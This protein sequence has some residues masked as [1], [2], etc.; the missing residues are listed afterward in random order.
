MW[1]AALERPDADTRSQAAAAIGLAHQRGMKEL[2][3][4]IGPLVRLLEKQDEHSAVRLAAARTLII[5]D[6]REAAPVLF[7]LIDKG[8]IE[9]REIIEPALAVWDHKP[10]RAMWLERL[11]QPPPH[12]RTLLLAIH[13]LGTV[14][15]EKALDGLRTLM[16]DKESPLPYRLA[17]ARALGDI[18]P[19]GFEADAKK[20]MAD[21]SGLL[22]ASVLRKHKSDESI[23]LLQTLAIDGEPGVA[24]IAVSRLVEIDAALVL[25]VI[26]KVLASPDGDVRSFGVDV[27]FRHPSVPN[28]ALLGKRLVDPHPEVR[29]KARGHLRQLAAK[30]ELGAAVLEQGQSNIA[31][32]DWRGQEQGI[33]LLTQLDQK[34]TVDRLFEL[35]ASERPEVHVAAG[36]G[37]RVLA[38]PETLPKAHEYIRERHRQLLSKGKSAGSISLTSEAVDRQLSQLVQFFGQARYRAAD[39]TLRALLPRGSMPGFTPVGGETRAA[40]AWALGWFHE[41]DPEPALVSLIEGRLTGDPGIGPDDPRLRRMAAVALGRMMAKQS[42]KELRDRASLDLPMTDHVTSACRWAAFHIMGEPLPK[43]LPALATQ[44]DWFLTPIR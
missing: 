36:W 43:V 38:V 37:I 20:L 30:P 19:S 41:G 29:A 15:E 1:L 4:A 25:P 40:S 22:A 18:R 7:G 35:L 13:A 9:L 21:G 33:Y 3:V 14:R 24:V 2:N 39:A 32:A 42:L 31:A 12:R 44:R 11:S 17:A 28:V 23:K 26:D 34:K 6:A 27:L 16:L 10:A 5:L 8:S